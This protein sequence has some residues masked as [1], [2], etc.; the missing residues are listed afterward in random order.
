MSTSTLPKEPFQPE[1]WKQLEKDEKPVRALRM[2]GVT[3]S[4]RIV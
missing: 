3:S 2:V 1:S 4:A